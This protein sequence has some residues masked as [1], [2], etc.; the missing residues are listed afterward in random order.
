MFQF[1]AGRKPPLGDVLDLAE[2]FAGGTNFETP[3]AVATGLLEAEYNQAGKMRGNIVFISDDECQVSDEWLR[4][5]QD[6][7]TRLGSGRTASPSAAAR[8]GNDRRLRQR[9]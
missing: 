2:F 5:W 1:P 9:A 7:K 8:H 6:A 4:A 3:L